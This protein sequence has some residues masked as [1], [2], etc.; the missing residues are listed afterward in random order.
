[1]LSCPC[2]R[3]GMSGIAPMWAGACDE[4]DS[5]ASTF[6]YWQSRYIRSHAGAWEREDVGGWGQEKDSLHFVALEPMSISPDQKGR[7]G[8]AKVIKRVVILS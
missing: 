5:L 1:M 3:V 7:M 4:K 6:L 8:A 2:S